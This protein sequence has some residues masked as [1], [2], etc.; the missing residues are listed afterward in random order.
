[1]TVDPQ[2]AFEQPLARPSAAELNRLLTTLEVKVVWLSECLVSPGWRLQLPRHA[3]LGIHYNLVGEGWLTVEDA[4]PIAL[5]PH[6]LVVI[7]PGGS[8]VLGVD[9]PAA[10]GGPLHVQDHRR[11]LLE[12]D[13]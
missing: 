9:A 1:M 10:P 4:P 5:R 13:A 6:T 11:S 2:S 7:P 12:R 3:T 8:V